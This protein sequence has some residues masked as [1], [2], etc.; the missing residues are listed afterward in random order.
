MKAAAVILAAGSSSRLGQPKQL[1]MLHEET[2]LDRAIRIAIEAGSAPVYVVLGANAEAI[3]AGSKYLHSV[4][5]T[6]RH[7]PISPNSVISTERAT[8]VEKPV[9][10]LQNESWQEGIASSIRTGVHAAA[11][12]EAILLLTCDQ[13]AVN[14]EH[15]RLL[16]EAAKQTSIA[17]SS[18]AG[19]IGIPAVFPEKFFEELLQ[20]RGD[21]GARPLL[22]KK[23]KEIITLPLA[24]GELDIDTPEDLLN[25][26]SF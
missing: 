2:L 25:L 4:I 26:P 5:P 12:A 1:V 22:N 21:T 15:L 17:A 9:V 8:R 18:Y 7:D 11:K 23:T 19:R 10:V 16:L 20:L 6:E 13:P 3:R 14:A 24:D